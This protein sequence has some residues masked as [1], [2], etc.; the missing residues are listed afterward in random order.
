MPQ[1]G[2]AATLHK[3][4]V[5]GQNPV[6][7]PFV[8]NPVQHLI[9]AACNSPQRAQR[10]ALHHIN[11]WAQSALSRVNLGSGPASMPSQQLSFNGHAIADY[12]EQHASNPPRSAIKMV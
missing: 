10:P 3:V 2:F 11:V 1:P 6:P 4:A 8:E 12:I 5:A 7:V 9:V